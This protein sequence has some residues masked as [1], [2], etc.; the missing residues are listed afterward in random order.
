MSWQ[1]R[2]V[3]KMTGNDRRTFG[4]QRRYLQIR[5]PTEVYRLL[6]AFRGKP[7]GY[8]HGAAERFKRSYE[9]KHLPWRWL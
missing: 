3:L 5:L 1:I 8:Y 4:L 9:T 7:S 2:L 6:F